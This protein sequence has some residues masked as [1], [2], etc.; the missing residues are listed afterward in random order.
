MV[1]FVWFWFCGTRSLYVALL[2]LKLTEIHLPLLPEFWDQK[3][4]PPHA[5]LH[6][7]FPSRDWKA[8]HREPLTLRGCLTPWA[9]CVEGVKER[10]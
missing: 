2:G 8:L 6:V 1:V 9:W 7:C 10:A 4:A 5:R 3:H